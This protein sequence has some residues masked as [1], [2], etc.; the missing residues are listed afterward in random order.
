MEKCNLITGEL[1]YNLNNGNVVD[2]YE[3]IN[4]FKMYYVSMWETYE[5]EPEYYIN[6]QN[7]I[8]NDI[9]KFIIWAHCQRQNII[10]FLDDTITYF[11]LCDYLILLE[12]EPCADV[13][14]EMFTIITKNMDAYIF[15][16]NECS[17]M[18]FVNII[19]GYVPSDEYKQILSDYGFK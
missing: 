5:T 18:K 15:N 12:F 1:K 11:D 17:G 19:N 2:V 7:V 4:D 10:N 9:D 14:N 6:V 8:E 13:V 16:Y 3:N